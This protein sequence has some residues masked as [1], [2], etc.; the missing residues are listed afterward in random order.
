MLVRSGGHAGRQSGAR[1][2]S[3]TIPHLAWRRL[4]ARPVLALMLWLAPWTVGS[5]FA[6]P[7]RSSALLAEHAAL[8]ASLN[9]SPFGEPLLLRTSPTSAENKGAAAGQV[10]AVLP[11]PLAQAVAPLRSATGLCSLL[12]LH[13][14][15]RDCQALPGAGGEQLQVLVGPMRESLPGLTHTM[16]LT[17]RPEADAPGYFSA[18]LSAAEGPMGASDL[19]V[20]LEAVALA[21]GQTYLHMAYSQTSGTAAR[22][23]TR[24]YLSTAGR[25]K[26][27][28][29]SDG[30]DA[31]GQPRPVGGE[32][33]VLER[34][35]MRHYLAL[36][37]HSSVVSGTP[38]A[39]LDARLR[40]WHALTERHAAQL[41]EMDLADYL[42]EKQAAATAAR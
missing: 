7:E 32:R 24:L 30:L 11:R 27:G 12:I 40:A 39:R 38:A 36:L 25:H 35:V 18:S 23:A 41:H 21:P 28:F 9:N 1:M 2:H 42:A 31:R 3:N 14:N 13:L 37:A 8:Q 6:S 20:R 33:A 16:R 17:L 5:V 4:W 19:R 15:V 29:S 10:L 34:N 26:I 22:L